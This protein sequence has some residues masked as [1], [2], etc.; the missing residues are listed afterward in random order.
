[1]NPTTRR[2]FL[3]NGIS[4]VVA[5]LWA[6]PKVEAAKATAGSKA[7]RL[8]APVFLKTDDP[9]ELAREHRRL[10]YGAAYCPNVP[11]NDSARIGE[12]SR[13]FKAAEVVI[14]E[15]GRWVRQECVSLED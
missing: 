8:G 2:M 15:V 3:R 11:L 10:G 1:M 14:A 7:V 4:A 6:L 5:G 12:F 13:A 9:V